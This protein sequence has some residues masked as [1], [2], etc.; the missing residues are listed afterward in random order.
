MMSNDPDLS[1][2]L[3]EAAPADTSATAVDSVALPGFFPPA[4]V[5]A[6]LSAIRD[7]QPVA[8]LASANQHREAL[9]SVFLNAIEQGLSDPGGDF[10]RNGMLFNYAAYFL[11]KWREPQ[12]G[13]LFLRWFSLPGEDAL[14]LG[15]DTV[16]HHG[17][18]FLASVCRGAIQPLK[19]LVANP[20]ANPHCRGQALRA[21]GVL[22]AWDEYPRESLEDDLLHW[23]REGLERQASPVW[24]DLAFVGVELELRRVLPELRRACSDG[25]ISSSFLTA[26]DL[27]QVE[28]APE[29]SLIERFRQHHPPIV[30]VVQETRWWAGFQQ[31]AASPPAAAGSASSQP[32]V[33]PPKVG[34]NDP[35][36]CGSGKKYKVCCGR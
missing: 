13:P 34:R 12:A 11:A 4:L 25:L 18:R 30:D 16:T 2:A 27:D 24:N 35:C 20:Q 19:D 3:P 31:G 8:A 23:A 1:S 26:A 14:E 5:V 10:A 9:T 22:A 33:A 17:S 6:Q 28:K 7:K 29:G 21:L 15:G 32:Y 36:P